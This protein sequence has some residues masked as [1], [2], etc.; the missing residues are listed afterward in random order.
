MTLCPEP[1]SS[2]G[3][4]YVGDTQSLV[5][6]VG[7]LGWGLKGIDI[8]AGIWCWEIWVS[9]WEREKEREIEG[10]RESVCVCVCVCVCDTTILTSW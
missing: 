7:Q 5:E 10:K 3:P 1:A 2:S 6:S 9:E 4:E 8:A